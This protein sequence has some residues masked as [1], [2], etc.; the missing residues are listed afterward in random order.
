MATYICDGSAN[1]HYVGA[2]IV[3]LEKG[4]KQT[5]SFYRNKK[6]KDTWIHEEFAM[7]NVLKIAEEFGD[8][9]ITIYNDSARLINVLCKVW[10]RHKRGINSGLP[11]D[12]QKKLLER[13]YS[14]EDSGFRVYLKHADQ[15]QNKKLIEEA[16]DL[17]RLYLKKI[18]KKKISSR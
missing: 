16:H 4:T 12:K 6:R 8:Q 3:R 9:K 5:F 15:L 7:E 11:T 1:K 17:S 10:S 14:L 13:I 2:G 18:K